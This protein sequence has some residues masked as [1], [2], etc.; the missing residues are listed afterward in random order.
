MPSLS[1]PLA[2]ELKKELQ[3]TNAEVIT[4]DNENY[5]E[6]ISRFSSSWEKD[7]GAVVRVTCTDEVSKVVH[8]ATQRHIPFVV[9]GGGYSTTGSSST[10]G[11]IIISMA[12]MSRV[13]VDQASKTIAV[14]GGATW[15]D[16]DRVAATFGLAVV[17]C[18]MNKT[19]V[20]GTSLGGGY[21]WLTG[22]YGLT[23]DNLLS[24]KIVLADGSVITA[25]ITDHPDL[26]W[27][28]RGA[29]QDFGVGTE[30]VFKAYPQKDPVFGG[31]LYFTADRLPK[32]V[33]FANRFE[34]GSTGNVGFF[35]GFSALPNIQDTAIFALVFYNGPRE[36][37]E[38]Y[39]A[40]VL[41][42]EPFINE[43]EMMPYP[44]INM[45]VNKAAD[46]GGRKKFGGT[47][48]TLPLKLE[49]MQELYEDFDRIMKTYP[50]T[51]ASVVKFELLPYTELIKVPN[52]A[53]AFSN[54]GRYYNAVTIFCWHDPELDPKMRAL[55]LDMVHKIGTRAGIAKSSEAN[56]G[57]GVYA[58]YAGHE[59]NARQLFGG[60][61]PRLQQLKLQYDPD[62]VFRKW[63]DMFLHTAVNSKNG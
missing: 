47:N 13:I 29:G 61:L 1:Y 20:G 6:S 49:F 9:Q 17:G 30:F 10:Y 38:R 51:S 57:V 12:K 45:M 27:A 28:A 32:I 36:E 25:S 46:F 24:V 4:P 23:I 60:N 37:A 52:D 5:V 22:S 34:E 8:F 53:T 14:E 21:G 62:N 33:E 16:V 11:G 7:A 26:F 44:K 35:F 41:S 15:E 54:R 31:Y 55:H 43:T 48:F 63:H 3:H 39:F 40:P 19:S 56:Q 2:L 59:A 18:T 42:Q 58:N 50:I